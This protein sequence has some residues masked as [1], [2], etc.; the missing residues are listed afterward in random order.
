MGPTGVGKSTV[1]FI[2][3]CYA[4]ILTIEQ[5]IDIATNQGGAGI[6]HSLHSCTADIRAVRVPGSNIILV[7][8]PGFDDTE[9][10]D[11]E[12]L[13]LIASWLERT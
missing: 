5:F 6:G 11:T 2:L 13:K 7:D 1:R 12:V 4:C 9:K 8:T 3:F 10:S